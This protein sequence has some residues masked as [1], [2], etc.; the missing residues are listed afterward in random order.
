MRDLVE[1]LCT[2][3]VWTLAQ[4]WRMELGGHHW[5]ASPRSP[6]Q[7]AKV[8]LCALQPPS[9]FSLTVSPAIVVVA[10]IDEA[11]CATEQHLGLYL[12]EEHAKCRLV[13]REPRLNRAY[14]NPDVCLTE[15]QDP[16]EGMK[17]RVG[18]PKGGDAGGR[19]LRCPCALLG[20][21]CWALVCARGLTQRK[22]R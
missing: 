8:W 9:F 3:R 21:A 1:E 18:L 17:K 20:L 4:G 7:G 15:R 16:N 14:V 5:V 19:S 12:G 10:P 2:F 11:A 13:V 6:W 22:G